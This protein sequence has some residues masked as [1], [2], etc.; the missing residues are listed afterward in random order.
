MTDTETIVVGA[1]QAGLAMSHQLTHRGVEHVVLERG[2]IG[3]GWRGRWESFCLVTPNWSVQLP[4]Y[5]YDGDDPDGFM[6]RDEVVSFLERYAAS[7]DAPVHPHTRITDVHQAPDSRFLVE[8]DGGTWTSEHLVLA[9]GAFQKA[10]L[11]E[12]AAS[13][14]ESL[15]VIDLTD[16]HSPD[17]IPEGDVLIVGSGQSGCQIAEELHAAGRRVVLACGRA[18]W[19]PRRIGDR[20]MFWWIA[21]SG[22]ADAPAHTLPT[23]ARLT[24]NIIATGRDG[25]RD[26][27]LRLLQEMGVTLAGR[28]L[29]ADADRAYFAAD[30]ADSVA[31]GDDKYTRFGDLVSETARRLGLAEPDFPDPEPFRDQGPSEIDLGPFGAVIFAGGFRPDFTSWL[32]W[33]GAFDEH[34]FPKHADGA[35]TE[36]DGLFFVGV[37][38]LRTR[39]SALLYGVGEDAAVVAEQIPAR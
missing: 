26:L 21:E 36:I 15:L 13:L 18:P 32:P 9:T 31:W 8:S 10:H 11:P 1:G 29:G 20:D 16:Y 25:G 27:H 2:A 23:E 5:P 4:G 38:F 6:P 34:G 39:K 30:L 17:A 7:F 3:E 24:A 14:P 37:H 22:F 19:A 35:S 12:G 33:P 28:F